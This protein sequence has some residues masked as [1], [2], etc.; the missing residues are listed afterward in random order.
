MALVR[1]HDAAFGIVQ[2][3]GTWGPVDPAIAVGADNKIEPNPPGILIPPGDNYQ[4]DPALT[5]DAGRLPFDP[6]DHM[7]DF[8]AE[9]NLRYDGAL[10]LL[11]GLWFGTNTFVE[12]ENMAMTAI[13]GD[14]T[15][16]VAK[17]V[18]GKHATL[19][20]DWVN[21]IIELD[22]FKVSQIVIACQNNQRAT[23]T[24]SG[25][26]R[27]WR[28]DS[29]VNDQAALDALT[30]QGPRNNVHFNQLVARIN[31]QGDAALASGD[32]I[33]IDS[34]TLTLDRQMDG[35]VTTGDAPFRDEVV[36]PAPG[37]VGTLQLNIPRW[38]NTDLQ[39]AHRNGT[40]QKAD[41]NFT[42]PQITD[43]DTGQD[44]TLAIDLPQLTVS[45]YEFN[46][47]GSI[48]ESITAEIG[49]AGTT[50]AGMNSVNPEIRLRNE[51]DAADG[52][53]YLT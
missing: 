35:P 22:F 21:A 4:E 5:G 53:A 11:V 52:G 30:L 34:F 38:Q 36:A 20:M 44:E 7:P 15:F 26:G 41:L 24:V 2:N 25:M 49:R 9:F 32:A 3:T 29:A 27:R 48:G 18:D 42:G 47:A 14:Q 33:S 31:N 19:A 46:E 13:G 37:W 1:P 43:G 8:E 23:I 50:P 17:N 51:R 6:G 39:N 10:W 45:G 40:V 28:N 12:L 16:N